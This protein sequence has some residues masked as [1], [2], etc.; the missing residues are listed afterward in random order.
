[1]KEKQTNKERT[2]E[3]K[4]K[5][6]LKSLSFCL[7]KVKTL[8]VLKSKLAKIYDNNNHTTDLWIKVLF[9]VRNGGVME[10]WRPQKR[11]P[12]FRREF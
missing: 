7:Q 8:K 6:N 10:A 12:D 3:R 1:M 5:K 11:Q 2:D 9:D 4:D